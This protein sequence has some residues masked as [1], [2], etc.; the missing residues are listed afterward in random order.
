MSLTLVV[1]WIGRDYPFDTPIGSV[2]TV[3]MTFYE[4]T[5]YDL[6]Y[7][8]SIGNW[9]QLLE[10]EYGMGFAHYGPFHH[11]YLSSAHHSL[12]C[13]HMFSTGIGSTDPD[14]FWH[15][16]HCLMYM[17]QA[18]ICN[19]DTTLEPG[20]FLQKNFTTDRTGAT[21]QCR[22]WKMVDGWMIETFRKWLKFNGYETP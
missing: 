6:A 12:H 9:Q 3:E 19:A 15:W 20:D 10:N 2:P 17:R 1:A 16:G 22:D 21:R 18:F 7:N 11:R 8:N 13:I 14:S 5:R 4:S